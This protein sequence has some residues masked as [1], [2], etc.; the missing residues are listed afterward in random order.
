ML[1]TRENKRLINQTGNNEIINST[2][3]ELANQMNRKFEKMNL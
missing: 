1:P 2:H 3:T